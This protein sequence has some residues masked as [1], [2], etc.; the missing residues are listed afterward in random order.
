M[1]FI[2]K[3]SSIS[4][5]FE[6]QVGLRDRCGDRCGAQFMLLLAE[7]AEFVAALAAERD[8]DEAVLRQ[9]HHRLVAE[10]LG[11]YEHAARL[12]KLI[13]VWVGGGRTTQN[14]STCW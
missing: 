12:D 14:A 2:R 5:F 9:F 11:E 7:S 10:Q 6:L 1:L 13:K 8:Y 4:F 3:N